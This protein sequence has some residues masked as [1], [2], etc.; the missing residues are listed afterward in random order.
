MNVYE[1]KAKIIGII[2]TSNNL[3]FR[4]GFYQITQLN[5]TSIFILIISLTINIRISKAKSITLKVREAS[6]HLPTSTN[7]IT[8]KKTNSITNTV[9]EQFQ[10]IS[11]RIYGLF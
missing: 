6:K 7:F 9:G 5:A 3:D 2:Q 1:M 11:F 4:I 10:P 8:T